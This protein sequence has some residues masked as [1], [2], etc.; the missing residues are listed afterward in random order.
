MYGA[1]SPKRAFATHRVADYV[2]PFVLEAA[3]QEGRAKRLA[4]DR[5]SRAEDH[6]Q[7]REYDGEEHEASSEQDEKPVAP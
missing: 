6:H 3:A 2:I 5:S 1:A 4:N 7:D